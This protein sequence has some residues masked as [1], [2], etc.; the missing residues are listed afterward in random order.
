ML[1]VVLVELEGVLAETRAMRA[2]ALRRSL[3]G[4][5]VQLDRPALEE[6]HSGLSPRQR[7]V[8]VLGAV[9]TW[10][11]TAL[12]LVVLQAE[13]E[14]TSLAGGGI[15]LAAGSRE[16][17]LQLQTQARLAVVTRASRRIADLVLGLGGLESV[18]DVIVTADDVVEAKP[19]S[20]MYEI[21]LARL[22]R[23]RAVRRKA[24]LALEDGRAGILA[25]RRAGVRCIAV[26]A[27]PP[28]DAMEA[29]ADAYLPTLEGQTLDTLSFLLRSGEEECR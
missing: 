9:A 20:S 13:R 11:E 5:G 28:G 12:D 7:A 23:R 25:A 22:S 21:A 26:G 14:F 8:A 16:C 24:C 19:S 1:D 3:A 17:L 6:D 18:F 27:I 15:S 4:F 2:D 29:E 10:D